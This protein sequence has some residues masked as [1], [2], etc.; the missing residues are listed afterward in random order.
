MGYRESSGALAMSKLCPYKSWGEA[1]L[2]DALVRAGTR[3]TSTRSAGRRTCPARS[4][5]PSFCRFSFWFCLRQGAA[6]KHG[7]SFHSASRGPT[8]PVLHGEG[9]PR[10]AHGTAA[11]RER[12]TKEG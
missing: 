4:P 6:G 11:G 10:A 12:G 5:M 7:G 8:G 2:G 1:L 9:P 3:R